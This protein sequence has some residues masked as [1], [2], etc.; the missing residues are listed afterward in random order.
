MTNIIL[1]GCSGKMGR[2]IA[3]EIAKRNDCK[4]VAGVDVFS[5]GSAEF[6]VY[7]DFSKVQEKADAII[8]FS[9]PAVLAGLL[10][11]AVS[12]NVPA[13]RTTDADLNSTPPCVT[14]PLT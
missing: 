1:S 14:T 13:V 6:P 5:D 11:Y 4:V 8:D 7:D 2:V 3:R 12:K 9:N 10:N